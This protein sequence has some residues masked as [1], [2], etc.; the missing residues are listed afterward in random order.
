MAKY[1]A[2]ASGRQNM[3]VCSSVWAR[4]GEYDDCLMPKG[5][6]EK[7]REERLLWGQLMSRNLHCE[8][9]I[10]TAESNTSTHPVKRPQPQMY[11]KNAQ[12]K[13]RKRK[14]ICIYI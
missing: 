8:H 12:D 5:E 3:N 14:K 1:H 6:T 7:N 10:V 4:R 11:G 9:C 13:E 2:N